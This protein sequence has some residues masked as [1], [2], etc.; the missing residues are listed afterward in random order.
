MGK[1]YARVGELATRQRQ[2]ATSQHHLMQPRI[3]S[4][5]FAQIYFE[6]SHRS[7]RLWRAAASARRFGKR[8]QRPDH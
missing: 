2:G 6:T 8:L 3:R 4:T 5:A 7:F 1:S